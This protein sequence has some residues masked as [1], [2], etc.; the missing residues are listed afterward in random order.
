MSIKRLTILGEIEKLLKGIKTT[1]GYYTNLGSNVYL[2]KMTD[3][4]DS[5]L[6]GVAIHQ[7]ENIKID[8]P[9]NFWN[10]ELSINLEIQCKDGIH[11]PANI[12]KYIYDVMKA[13]GSNRTLTGTCIEIYYERDRIVLKEES[14]AIAGA[15]ISIKIL[16]RTNEWS[17]D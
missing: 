9:Y 3:W 8:S 7:V 16:Y 17:E 13:I 5:E 10:Q 11:T 14:K 6:P 15:E 1:S 4:I 12:H 2:S